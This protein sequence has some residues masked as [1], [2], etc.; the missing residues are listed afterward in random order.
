MIK[1]L[2]IKAFC[3]I[4]AIIGLVYITAL[5]FRPLLAFGIT[6]FLLSFL[7]IDLYLL[8][9]MGPLGAGIV[10]GCCAFFLYGITI[11][12]I[13]RYG[14]RGLAGSLFIG[15]FLFFIEI[16]I[17]RYLIKNKERDTGQGVNHQT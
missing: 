2:L 16:G 9:K 10:D 4:P 3:M 14:L 6:Y 11:D 17:H 7:I 5:P 13:G 8:P 15:A 12:V 1:Q